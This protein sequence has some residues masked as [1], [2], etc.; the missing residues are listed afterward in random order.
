[1]CIEAITFLGSRTNI[2]QRAFARRY[3]FVDTS[4]SCLPH[5]S[6]PDAPE[7]HKLALVVK[8]PSVNVGEIKKP[9]RSHAQGCL[10]EEGMVTYS[11]ILAWRISGTEEPGKLQSMGSPRV[12]NNW[13][14]SIHMHAP[15]PTLHDPV[16]VKLCLFIHCFSKYLLNSQHGCGKICKMKLLTSREPAG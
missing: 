2:I 5:N 3:S 14:D 13:I 8:N 4:L 11:S 1:M 15:V 16:I 9:V 10:L 7:I 6:E 12:G